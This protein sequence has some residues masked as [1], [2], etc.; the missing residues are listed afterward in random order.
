M[1]P[2]IDLRSEGSAVEGISSVS[3][4]GGTVVVEGGTPGGEGLQDLVS[5]LEY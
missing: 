4:T 2:C 5:I 1:I 3:S